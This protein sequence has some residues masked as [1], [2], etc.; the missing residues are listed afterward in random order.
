M[1]FSH[2]SFSDVKANW[3]WWRRIIHRGDIKH[4]ERERERRLEPPLML[5]SS[6][7]RVRW[8]DD[9]IPPFWADVSFELQ[10]CC[11]F[12]AVLTFSTYISVFF[13]LPLAWKCTDFHILPPPLPKKTT[14]K[15][16]PSHSTNPMAQWINYE[17]VRRHLLQ[18]QASYWKEIGIKCEQCRCTAGS[19]A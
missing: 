12:K 1:T 17:P 7:N 18:T 2:H 10:S 9:I 15:Q 16:K 14:K 4:S 6:F 5:T 11:F 8:D 3:I 19:D 13:F